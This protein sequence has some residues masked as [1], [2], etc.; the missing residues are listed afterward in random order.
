VTRLYGVVLAVLF[1]VGATAAPAL[2]CHDSYR[3]GHHDRHGYY[4]DDCDS[5]GYYCDGYGYYRSDRDDY[6]YHRRY[7]YDRGACV[8]HQSV[9]SITVEFL[10]Y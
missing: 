4:D 7:Y 1:T 2:A 6:R 8:Y 10:C 3:Y 5:D 9:G